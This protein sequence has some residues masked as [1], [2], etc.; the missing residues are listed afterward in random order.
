MFLSL[1]NGGK[2]VSSKFE[3]YSFTF[4]LP[5]LIMDLNNGFYPKEKNSKCNNKN[6]NKKPDRYKTQNMKKTTHKTTTAP[7][8]LQ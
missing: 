4:S 5:Q 3:K 6:K 2:K 7:L 8:G 1:W